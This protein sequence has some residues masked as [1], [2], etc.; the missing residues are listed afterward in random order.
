MNEKT[1]RELAQECIDGKWG[2]GPGRKKKIEAAGYDYEEVKE[3]VAKLR[4]E[5]KKSGK[6][7]SAFDRSSEVDEVEETTE[8]KDE[9]PEPV[10]K[11]STGGSHFKEP[12][13]KEDEKEETLT[14]SEYFE[15]VKGKIN[16]ET[17]ENVKRLFDVTMKQL[18]KFTITGQKSAAKELYA[19]CLYLEKELKL[20][21]L[22]I[23]KYVKRTD[24][25]DYI[26]NVADDCVCVIEMKNFDRTIPDEII[27]TVSKSM[28]I[29]DEFYVVFTDYT[30]ETR[31]KVAKE[32]RDKDPILFG[33]IFI[34][35]KVSPKMYFIGDWV[36]DY[37]DLTLDKMVSEIAKKESKEESEIVY[38]ISD[39]TNLDSIEELLFGT[40][41]R[42]EARTV[43]GK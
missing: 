34:D 37:C 22:G 28:D 17:A 31:S 29:F 8:E 18:K 9:I 10:E 13:S 12:E 4:A 19:R 32:K 3:E 16:E 42:V 6:K 5:M 24:I 39:E 20:I 23:T 43:A 25:D 14:P 11:K 30:G 15:T 33:N 36:D 26:D 7:K 1:I 41:K 2:R 40:S 35:G 21:N 38:D 27:D